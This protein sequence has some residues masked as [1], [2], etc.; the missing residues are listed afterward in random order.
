MI[1]KCISI[2]G[3]ISTNIWS[4][5]ILSFL[6]YCIYI[7]EDSLEHIRRHEINLLVNDVARIASNRIGHVLQ[8]EGQ[9]LAFPVGA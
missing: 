4:T 1:N 8:L 9:E 3:A 2:T 6:L 7:Y 5:L